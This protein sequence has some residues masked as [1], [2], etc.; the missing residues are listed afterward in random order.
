MLRP[1]N[2][3]LFHNPFEVLGVPLDA[4]A[5]DFRRRVDEIELQA[6]LRGEAV[7]L[8]A[9]KGAGQELEDP[10]LRLHAEFFSPW[11][12]VTTYPADA[13][14]EHDA[15]LGNL[16][17][18]L[19]QPGPLMANDFAVLVQ[20]TSSLRKGPVADAVNA[21]A[22]ILG[23]A[24]DGATVT[25]ILGGI[26][27]AG[28]FAA[29][30]QVVTTRAQVA[31][32]AVAA[33]GPVAA[34]AARQLVT[35]MKA[36]IPDVD[37]SLPTASALVG[38]LPGLFEVV[39]TL[40]GPFPDLAADLEHTSFHFGQQA[41]VR[42]FNEDRPADAQAVL[43][44]L[45]TQPLTADMQAIVAS[46]LRN[47]RYGRHWTEANAAIVRGDLLGAIASLED[48]SREAWSS[49]QRESTERAIQQLRVA[50]ARK[51]RAASVGGRT[52][53]WVKSLAGTGLVIAVLV[54]IGVLANSE[55]D[56]G[57]SPAGSSSS[58]S[59]SYSTPF[60]S[61]DAAFLEEIDSYLATYIEARTTADA[62]G[63][64][65]YDAARR[66][67]TFQRAARNAATAAS[68]LQSAA[69][70][71]PRTGS[72]RTAVIRWATLGKSYWDGLASG[73]SS[74]DVDAWNGAVDLQD[75]L[76]TATSGVQRA[77]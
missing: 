61:G 69:S 76:N 64:E 8:I 39:S 57:S 11:A 27:L 48:A 20:A 36:C 31:A 35:A 2:S 37:A 1:F 30:G 43:E 15:W 16:R 68:R 32:F 56:A 51:Q 25:P 73:A 58:G 29:A 53:A 65:S 45:A 18:M 60:S 17:G 6:R 34:D 38:T 75:G 42:H 77:C 13:A 62:T 28:I 40:K 41:A 3:L 74:M 52:V 19:G 22:G 63:V 49:E 67:V 24:P 54:G 59:S 33:T 46:D 66:S 47:A 55:D 21:R 10:L 50:A 12:G 72:C 14:L 44:C 4:T 23:F 5:K 7:D 26:V 71:S 9:V 70:R